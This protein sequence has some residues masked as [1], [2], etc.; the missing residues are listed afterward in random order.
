MQIAD[1]KNTFDVKQVQ[2]MKMLKFQP[3]IVTCKKIGCLINFRIVRTGVDLV[4]QRYFEATAQVTLQTASR[5]QKSTLP[6]LQ[7]RRACKWL[8]RPVACPAIPIQPAPSPKQT[9]SDKPTKTSVGCTGDRTN[10]YAQSNR[11]SQYAQIASKV[12]Y[13]PSGQSRQNDHICRLGLGDG[14]DRQ[15]F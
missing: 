2:R 15:D 12:H 9:A 7:S 10:E 5:V 1:Q 4:R 3:A 14:P 11:D 13:S 6:R 8:Y